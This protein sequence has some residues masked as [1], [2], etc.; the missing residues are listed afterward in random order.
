M[1]AEISGGEVS[2]Y[3]GFDLL[4]D[5]PLQPPKVFIADKGCDSNYVRETMSSAAS[6]R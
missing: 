6:T 3:K 1:K 4:R 5:D 2:D